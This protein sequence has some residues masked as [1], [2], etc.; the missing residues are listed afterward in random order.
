MGILWNGISP[1]SL[2]YA[3]AIDGFDGTLRLLKFALTPPPSHIQKYLQTVAYKYCFSS[4]CPIIFLKDVPQLWKLIGMKKE[5]EERK[6]C[7]LIDL[8]FTQERLTWNV[9]WGF[10]AAFT[11]LHYFLKLSL[12][13]WTNRYMHKSFSCLGNI[14]QRNIFL[15]HFHHWFWCCFCASSSS[16]KPHAWSVSQQCLITIQMDVYKLCCG[17]SWV[18]QQLKLW[19]K[20]AEVIF[21]HIR[22]LQR[23]CIYL[24]TL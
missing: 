14:L 11:V 21:F 16:F 23:S 9:I 1:T 22:C 10:S 13:M 24:L 12:G 6:M 5:G 4:S 17:L 19:S 3:C 7:C 2:Q 15:S 20:Y 18:S 8:V